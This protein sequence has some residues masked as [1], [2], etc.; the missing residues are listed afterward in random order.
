MLS[1]INLFKYYLMT[2]IEIIHVIFHA[3]NHYIFSTTEKNIR[4][5]TVLITGSGRGLGQQM[6]ILFAKRG[7]IVVL[8]DSND[9]GNSQ[10]LELISALNIE[11]RIFSYTCD[12]ANRDE[13]DL[14]VNKIQSEVGDITILV[15]TTAVVTSNSMLDMPEEEF[16]RCLNTNL[17]SAYWLI[18]RILPSMMRRNHGHIITVLGATAVFG[19]GNF[20]A[21]CTAKFG[22]TGLMESVD[23]ELTLGGYDGI[24]TT[25]VV[26]HYLPTHLLPLSKTRFHPVI[27]PLTL[28]YAAKKIMHAILINRRFVCVPRLYY[29]VPFIKGILPARAFVILLNTFLNPKLSSDFHNESNRKSNSTSP[30]H[31]IHRKRNHM[32]ACH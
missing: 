25:S 23:H 9:I 26:S 5:E 3:I 29:L 22:L 13:I 17:F 30:I 18:R 6:A 1:Y 14:L 27:P 28:D 12:I 32:S 16:S 4:N 20:S 21:V 7:A 15:N 19:L 24:Y 8:C 10:T 2:F 31:H 11:Q